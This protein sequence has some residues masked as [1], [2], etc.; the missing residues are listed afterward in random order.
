MSRERPS[1][2]NIQGSESHWEQLPGPNLGSLPS[3]INALIHHILNPT[4]AQLL[5]AFGICKE[6]GD[7]TMAPGTTAEG[8]LHN[9]SPACLT[10]E[11]LLPFTQSRACRNNDQDSSM[12]VLVT[13]L[14]YGLL[15]PCPGICCALLEAPYP[16]WG[17]RWL[18]AQNMG[19]IPGDLEWLMDMCGI[20]DGPIVPAM[21]PA[22]IPVD[23]CG[24]P[25]GPE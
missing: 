2:N 6:L 8:G 7:G 24:E 17:M 19:L 16:G 5:L 10:C 18:W 13:S 3:N 22:V 25:R 4:R 23:I 11:L 12:N 15:T 14:M 20:L 21:P 1:F 9:P